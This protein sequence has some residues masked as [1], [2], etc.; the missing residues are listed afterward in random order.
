VA[1]R[2]MRLTMGLTD[3][4]EGDSG[5]TVSQRKAAGVWFGA[6]EANAVRASFG[7]L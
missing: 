4:E 2:E 6:R 1:V 7:M 5:S 3:R